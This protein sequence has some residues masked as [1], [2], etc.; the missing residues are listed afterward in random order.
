MDEEAFHHFI[1][2]TFLERLRLRGHEVTWEQFMRAR[3][4]LVAKH[5]SY[6]TRKLISQ[7]TKDR[8]LTEELLSEVRDIV[9]GKDVELQTLVPGARGV[10][11]AVSRRYPLGLIANQSRSIRELLRAKD[12]ERYFQIIMISEEEGLSKPDERLFKKAANAAHCKPHEAVM[13]GDRIDND[14]APAKKVGF[15]TVRVRW[16]IFKRQEALSEEE[17]P[18]MEVSNLSEVPEALKRLSQMP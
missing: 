8:M 18:D 15:K 12:I 2:K 7:F 13:I 14:I 10:L 9:R 1:Y 16:G 17:R 4:D 5:V 6:F 3:D 11:E